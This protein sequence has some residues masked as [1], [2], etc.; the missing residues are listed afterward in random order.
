MNAL[1]PLQ[2]RLRLLIGR[3]V[4]SV[5]N[6]ALK[7]QNVQISAQAGEIIDEVER[8][9]NYG[10]SSVPPAGSEAIIVSVG[11]KRQSLVAVVVDDKNSRLNGL[12]SGDSALYH[13]DGHHLLLTENGEAILICKSFKVQAENE[14][15][16]DAPQ[17]RVTG[18]LAII[19]TSTA[20]DHNS[21]GVSG[22]DHTHGNVQN[23]PGRTETP[24]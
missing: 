9:Q 22:K 17:T 16:F 2:R 12:K 6:D 4:I 10:V 13:A 19:G 1:K 15:V 20:A 24:A 21:N 8:F 7:T 23:G 5:V 14:I 11:G 18:D 3:A